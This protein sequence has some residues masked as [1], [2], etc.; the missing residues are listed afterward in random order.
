M[1]APEIQ[2]YISVYSHRLPLQGTYDPNTCK[3]LD[4]LFHKVKEQGIRELWL[5]SDRGTLKDFRDCYAGYYEE[6]VDPQD[7]EPDLPLDAL[8]DWWED[9]FPEETVRYCLR[10]EEDKQ[11]ERRA[12]YLNNRKVIEQDNRVVQG[13]KFSFDLSEL[14]SWLIQAATQ[15]M[16]I[17]EEGRRCGNDSGSS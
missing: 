9:E 2:F 13:C 1:L 16:T 10:V 5:T 17:S 8:Q 7:N 11:Y 14:V 12:V 4:E 15:V 3:L 6:T